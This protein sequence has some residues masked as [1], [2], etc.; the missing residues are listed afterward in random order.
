MVFRSENAFAQGQ[1]RRPKK[2]FIGGE[3]PSLVAEVA[4]APTSTISRPLS[5]SLETCALHYW[6]RNFTA[7]PDDVPD[8]AQEY[9]NF[10]LGDSGRCSPDSSLQQALSACT[11]ATFGKMRHVNTA[12]EVA[13]RHYVRSIIQMR[14]EIKDMSYQNSDLLLMATMLMTRYEVR[15]K[16]T[17]F[18]NRADV[19]AVHET[20]SSIAQPCSGRGGLETLQDLHSRAWNSWATPATTE[21]EFNL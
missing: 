13:E 6:E 16:S 5:I 7:A 8:V 21:T 4:G 19:E 2:Q 9:L 10:V 17:G 11:L 12:L 14:K 3:L 20:T 18:L 1:R 15:L